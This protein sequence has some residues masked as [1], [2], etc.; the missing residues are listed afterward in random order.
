MTLYQVVHKN[1]TS[2]FL[3]ATTPASVKVVIRIFSGFTQ[4]LSII[5]AVLRAI[6]WVLPV[7]GQATTIIGQ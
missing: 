4:V 3:M 7:Q 1:L 2:L 5:F 6:I